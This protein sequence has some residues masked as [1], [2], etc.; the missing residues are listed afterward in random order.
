MTFENVAFTKGV[1]ANIKGQA[2]KP[3]SSLPEGANV[4]YLACADCDCG[5]LGWHV[6]AKGRDLGAD[7]AAEQEGQVEARQ[8]QQDTREFL[9]DVTRCRYRVEA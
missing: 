8:Q 4:R 7:V 3:L 9:V 2:E 1:L 6:E 5:P